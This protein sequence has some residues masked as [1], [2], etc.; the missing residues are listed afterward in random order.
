MFHSTQSRTF[1][2]PCAA[3]AN[4][5]RR[6]LPQLVCLGTC[7]GADEETWSTLRFLRRAR[8]ASLEVGKNLALSGASLFSWAEVFDFGVLIHDTI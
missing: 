3:R 7:S 2:N 8:C 1:T 6:E 5:L 4:V